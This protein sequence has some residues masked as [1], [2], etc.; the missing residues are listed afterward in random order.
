MNCV[1]EKRVQQSLA[2]SCSLAIIAST[3]WYVQSARKKIKLSK[4]RVE[5]LCPRTTRAA[6]RLQKELY[7][8]LA[9]QKG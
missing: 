8:S 9:L 6:Y 5:Y 7:F 2:R 1:V 4:S 3:D